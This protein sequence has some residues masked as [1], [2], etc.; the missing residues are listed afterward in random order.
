MEAH[1]LLKAFEGRTSLP[2]DVNDVLACLREQGNTDSIEF[3]GADLDPDILQGA[4]KIWHARSTLYGDPDRMVNI[5]YHRGH[6]KDWQ[7]MICCKEI[8]HLIDPA[9]AYTSE[10]EAINKLA[11]E[12]GLPPEMQD[13]FNEM[14]MTNVDR[15]AELRAAAILLPFEARAVMRPFYEAQK[16]SIEDIARQ[17][18]IPRKY[19]GIVMH[20]AWDDLYATMTRR[21]EIDPELAKAAALRSSKAP[22]M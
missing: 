15:V 18:D 13:P 5:Y 10:A 8:L 4:I 17:A 19:A 22:G 11:D 7:R 9:W 1:E 2:I 3:I 20:P 21:K 6:A 16:L 14:P 12:I